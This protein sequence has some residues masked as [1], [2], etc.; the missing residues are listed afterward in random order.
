MP[1]YWWSGF[2]DSELS[3][4][5]LAEKNWV[6]ALEERVRTNRRLA[7]EIDIAVRSSD[8]SARIQKI[9]E[10]MG[11]I[12]EKVR[13]LHRDWCAKKSY[14]PMALKENL[15]CDP[16]VCVPFH[17]PTEEDWKQRYLEETK[18]ELAKKEAQLARLQKEVT[19]LREEL[20][21]AEA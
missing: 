19:A 18:G 20:E 8:I 4:V 6:L 21:E 11:A 9:K 12:D 13:A 17:Q 2:E 3:A 5:D 15:G 14:L 1:K 10:E 16:A 7:L